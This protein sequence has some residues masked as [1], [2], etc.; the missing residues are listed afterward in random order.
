VTPGKPADP[1]AK[2]CVTNA[3]DCVTKVVTKFDGGPEPA[4]PAQVLAGTCEKSSVYESE[5]RTFGP[6]RQ[7]EECPGVGEVAPAEH[8]P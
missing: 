5:G 8:R 3:K 4:K 7:G 1:N 2:D 6:P